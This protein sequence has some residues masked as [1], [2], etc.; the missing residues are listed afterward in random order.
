MKESKKPKII[1]TTGKRKNAVARAKVVAGT[2]RIHLNSKP[3]EIWGNEPLRLWLKEPIILAG[4]VAKSVDISVNARGGGIVGQAEASRM[5]IA[6]GLV[7][8][9]NNKELRQ[10]YL[11]YDRNMLVY[12]P[13]RNE[14]HHAGGASK[15]GSRRHK[16]RS[17]R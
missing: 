12:D 10:R 4:D 15:R 2:G 5:A 11:E 14:P 3:V 17:K 16:Q 9:S 6:K 8:F 1:F 13:R 7:E